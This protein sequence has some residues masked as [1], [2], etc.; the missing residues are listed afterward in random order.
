ML[1]PYCFGSVSGAAPPQ[2]LLDRSHGLDTKGFWAL[3]IH[4]VL[5]FPK[6]DFS[7]S[8]Q[9]MPKFIRLAKLF[10][11]WICGT[12][13][14]AGSSSSPVG[15]WRTGEYQVDLTGLSFSPSGLLRTDFLSRK[16]PLLIP[17]FFSCPAG[18]W[19]EVGQAGWVYRT[20]GGAPTGSD[21]HGPYVASLSVSNLSGPYLHLKGLDSFVFLP[22]SHYFFMF[23]GYPTTSTCCIFRYSIAFLCIG[24]HL[25]GNAFHTFP[26]YP[27]S[28][29][30]YYVFL[31]CELWPEW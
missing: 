10:I 9:Q 19:A 27:L 8:N 15:T 1:I 30:C 28:S 3:K 17:L 22:K 2:V 24:Q 29:Q 13:I 11:W 4:M 16:Y 6:L 5:L 31:K 14:W 25:T 23:S 7:L 12:S 18:S 21:H 26:Q 20:G